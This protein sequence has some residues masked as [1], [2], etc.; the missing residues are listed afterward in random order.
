MDTKGQKREKYSIKALLV[1][2]DILQ[3]QVLLGLARY[4]GDSRR[5]K[6]TVVRLATTFLKAQQVPSSNHKDH[7]YD[8]HSDRK[9]KRILR[10]KYISYQLQT[11][12]LR[13][14]CKNKEARD[15][16]ALTQAKPEGALLVVT[17]DMEVLTTCS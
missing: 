5:D 4:D 13:T 12:V 15:A 11:Q 16:F 6:A 2:K 8:H 9:Y 14:L 7:Q 17:E 3:S 10:L 1:T